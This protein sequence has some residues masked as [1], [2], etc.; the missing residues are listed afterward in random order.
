MPYRHT[1]C[2]TWT[3]PLT[4]AKERPAT[5]TADNIWTRPGNNTMKRLYLSLYLWPAQ[6]NRTGKWTH[7]CGQNGRFAARLLMVRRSSLSAKLQGLLQDAL[8]DTAHTESGTI[9]ANQAPAGHV[10]IGRFI[11]F[12]LHIDAP[13]HNLIISDTWRAQM[14][15]ICRGL[16]I[17]LGVRRHSRNA[18]YSIHLVESFFVPS[19]VD[20]HLRRLFLLIKKKL[21]DK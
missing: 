17:F 15:E 20:F 1:L 8:T 18:P 13:S 7:T 10:L 11:L 6:Y 21:Q 16:G 12:L 14:N 2:N 9:R 19:W 3:G 5:Q 4:E